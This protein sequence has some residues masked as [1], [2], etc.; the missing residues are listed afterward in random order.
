L[1]IKPLGADG[2]REVVL[3][4]PELLGVSFDEG[5]DD[6]LV[7][8]TREQAGGLPLLSDTLDVLWKEMQRR[9]DKVLRWSEPTGKGVDVTRKL[10]ERADTFVQTHLN[11]EPVI[12]RLFCVRLAHVPQQGLAT[13]QTAFLDDLDDEERTLVA[14]L[15]SADQ[16]IV[17]TGELDG[18]PFAEVAHEALFIAWTTLREWISSRRA[19]YAW[20][21]QLA[22][23]RKDWDTHGRKRA[24]LLSGRPLER[25]RSFLETD[26][27]DIPIG[28]A[29]FV[30]KSVRRA[31]RAK[32]ASTLAIVTSILILAGIS[33]IAGWNWLQAENAR[34]LAVTTL[35]RMANTLAVASESVL[36]DD[37]THAALLALEALPD[38]SSKN[39]TPSIDRAET[40]LYNALSNITEINVLGGPGYK[41]LRASFDTSGTWVI[42]LCDDYN[43]RIW[44]V[45]T[46]YLTGTIQLS[47]TR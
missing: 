45:E 14:A 5:L 41:I 43:I 39:F 15:A 40:A 31:Q 25:A 29:S 23:E 6:T 9:G 24:G 7:T 30:V 17:A 4:P 42:A 19:F 26:S 32:I 21:T 33:S 37:P 47:R 38:E 10:A 2:L 1:D 3:R 18:H 22:A 34:Q 12:R 46:A 35:T 20:V 28:D 36:P 8:S 16:R 11:Q 44:N 27:A 13:S